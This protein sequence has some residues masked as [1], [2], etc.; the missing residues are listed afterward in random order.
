MLNKKILV[1]LFVALLAFA[2]L[3]FLNVKAES[4]DN[5]LT[6]EDKRYLYE[7]LNFTDLEVNTIPF[8]EAKFLIE[9]QAIVV[10]EFHEI[11]DMDDV[12]SDTNEITPLAIPS[13]DL[14]FVGKILKLQNTVSGYDAFYAYATYD[15]LK[16]PVW[17]LT[18]KI[19]IGFPTSLGV[20]MPTSNGKITGHHASHW[21][22]NTQTGATTNYHTTTTVSDADPSGGVASA[23]NL[24]D[25]INT[26]HRLQGRV[27]QTFHVKTTLS[28][29]ANVKF[30]YGHKTI[31]GT[32]TVNLIPTS[33][34]GISPSGNIEVRTYYSDFSY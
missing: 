27:S 7:V 23:V 24:Y 8:E 14:S 28:G 3:S 4:E 2:S 26:N 9:N 31:S 11:F 6:N 16:R 12:E 1:S 17:K 32:P 19:S 5:T 33:G 15:W 10:S 20:Y 25:T 21:I 18:D 34:L 29:K 30:E 22:Y 13:G